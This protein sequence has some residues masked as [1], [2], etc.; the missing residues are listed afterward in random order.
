ME[1]KSWI[2]R[3]TDFFENCFLQFIAFT[4]PFIKSKNCS[5]I[6]I[7]TIADVCSG[8]HLVWISYQINIKIFARH[9]VRREIFA[10]TEHV[11]LKVL[12]PAHLSL[13]EVGF[14][15][16]TVLMSLTRKRAFY[17]ILHQQDLWEIF[18]LKIY[19]LCL[20]KTL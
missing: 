7:I 19:C 16:K 10:F 9:F 8:A 3:S 4:S 13:F 2:A 15:G 1:L 5:L 14:L 17:Q 20:F 11:F 6:V 18:S 12:Q